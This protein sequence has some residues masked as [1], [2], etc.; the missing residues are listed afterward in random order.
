MTDE[1]LLDLLEARLE[2][3]GPEGSGF[4]LGDATGPTLDALQGLRGRVWRLE[5]LLHS[6][7]GVMVSQSYLNSG[8]PFATLSRRQEVLRLVARELGVALPNND[9]EETGP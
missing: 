5:S 3:S 4:S 1:Q 9:H 6:A 2:Q 8:W 7:L